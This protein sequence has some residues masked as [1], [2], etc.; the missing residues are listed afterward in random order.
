MTGFGLAMLVGCGSSRK[1]TVLDYDTYQVVEVGAARYVTP[2]GVTAEKVQ[3]GLVRHHVESLPGTSIEVRI[4]TDPPRS[5]KVDGDEERRLYLREIGGNV[6]TKSI[7]YHDLAGRRLL[8][9]R[10]EGIDE[11]GKRLF[12]ILD[13]VRESK[14]TAI[15]R[16]LGPAELEN[17][18]INFVDDFSREIS[19]S[20]ETLDEFLYAHHLGPTEQ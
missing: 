12:G 8:R 9:M 2:A 18:I 11:D 4:K 5:L 10:I 6:R 20:D 7:M 14:E 13:V 16:V 1:T 3:Q 19:L 17:E 15:V